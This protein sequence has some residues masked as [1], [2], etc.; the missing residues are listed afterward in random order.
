MTTSP[1]SSIGTRARSAALNYPSLDHEPPAGQLRAGAHSD[2]GSVTILRAEPG[3][4]GLQIEAPDGSW[5]EVPVAPDAFVVNVGDLLARWSNDRWASTLHR[6]VPD[7][8]RRQSLAFFHLPNWDAVIECV[9]GEPPRH[10][11]VIAGE[12]L[13]RKFERSVNL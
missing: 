2:Y 10:A 7:G 13:M 8:R 4:S 1:R 3:S 11:P 9:P 6:V 12:H 5:V